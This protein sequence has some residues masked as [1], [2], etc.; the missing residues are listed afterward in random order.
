MFGVCKHRT[1]A[2]DRTLVEHREHFDAQ[3][4]GMHRV[5]VGAHAPV[6]ET[7]LNH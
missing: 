4:A 7:Q 6:S 3:V 2:M 5:S 1:S